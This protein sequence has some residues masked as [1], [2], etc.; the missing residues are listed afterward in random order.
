VC[1]S[2]HPV[3]RGAKGISCSQRVWSAGRSRKALIKRDYPLWAEGPLIESRWS[4]VKRACQYTG[5][6]PKARHRDLELSTCSFGNRCKFVT[7]RGVWAWRQKEAT[8]IDE[9]FIW[10][11]KAHSP[12]G[13]NPSGET[14]VTEKRNRSHLHDCAER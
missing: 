9:S 11:S 6:L 2:T 13:V 14:R 4:S 10:L 8:R 5:T 7:R 1:S 3:T 12:T